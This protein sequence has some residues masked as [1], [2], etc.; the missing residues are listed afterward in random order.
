MHTLK[1]VSLI[2]VAL[3]TMFSFLTGQFAGIYESLPSQ[4]WSADSERIF[5][6]S[7]C[8]NNKVNKY[9]HVAEDKK[10]QVLY[11]NNKKKLAHC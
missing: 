6:S 4:C 7:A 5:F 8:E 10:I 1:S 2:C 11:Q 3:F 9:I